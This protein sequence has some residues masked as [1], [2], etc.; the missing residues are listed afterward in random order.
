M[1]TISGSKTL[2]FGGVCKLT[3][4]F[5]FYDPDG[6][7][8]IICEHDVSKN[9]RSG[10]FVSLDDTDGHHIVHLKDGTVLHFRWKDAMAE[11]DLSMDVEHYENV[12][13]H[14][15]RK[16]KDSSN[17]ELKYVLESKKK[18]SSKDDSK[19]ININIQDSTVAVNGAPV[20]TKRQ[21]DA[22]TRVEKV[23]RNLGICSGS[24]LQKSLS[25]GLWPDAGPLGISP[26]DVANLYNL[27]GKSVEVMVGKTKKMK[28]GILGDVLKENEAKEGEII[29][30][31]DLM[32]S[33]S[34]SFVHANA[35]LLKTSTERSLATSYT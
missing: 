16:T 8:N 30:Y 15:V 3:G 21:L 31:V 34:Q 4:T 35:H 23:I 24:N 10:T 14:G 12:E 22:T 29:A 11:C 2:R 32:F 7:I 6:K 20:L 25:N 17:Q 18:M 26:Q 5:A 13:C 28:S 9:S 33:E 19:R 1:I 27:K